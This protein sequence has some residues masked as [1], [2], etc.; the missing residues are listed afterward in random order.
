MNGDAVLGCSNSSSQ[1]LPV[2]ICDD[3][4][5]IT[6]RWFV[7]T[8]CYSSDSIDSIDISDSGDSSDSSESNDSSDNSDSCDKT[9][10]FSQKKTFFYSQIFVFPHNKTF[11]T[12]SKFFNQQL[13]KA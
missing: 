4:I 10:F 8:L 11:S 5:N 1:V 7:K 6:Y 3:E 2:Y 12:P 9:N 13:F